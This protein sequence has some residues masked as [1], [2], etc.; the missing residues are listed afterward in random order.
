MTEATSQRRRVGLVL[1]GGGARGAY[2]A[3][4]LAH[5]FEEIY[6]QLPPGFEFDVLSGTSVGAIHAAYVAASAHMEPTPRTRRLA[7]TW[8]NMRV[9][10]VLQLSAGDLFGIPLRALGMTRLGKRLRAGAEVIGGL[11]DIAPLE[12][13][14]A[15]RIPWDHLRAN[16]ERGTPGALCVS[17]T[18]V[19]TGR[20]NVFM[21]GPLAD[22]HPWEFDPNTS[23]EPTELSPLHVR[24]SAAI[25][26]F[27]PA[28]RIGERYY[29]DGGLRVNTP[30]SPALRLGCERVLVVGLKHLA[31]L[32]EEPPAYPEEV[33]AQPVFMLGKVLNALMLDRLEYDLQRVGLVNALIEHGRQIY[34]GD[35]LEKLNVAV[36]AQRGADY[37]DVNALTLRPSQ[38]IGVIAAESYDRQ[39]RR[40]SMGI[41]PALLTRVAQ[42]GVPK[43][44]ADLLSYLLFDR[45]FTK[46][47]MELGREDAKAQSD[48]IVELLSG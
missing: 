29:L 44:E 25:P 28:V 48:A 2:E 10:D 47:L 16:L 37:R 6:P 41:L 15:Q 12:R 13:L 43:G 1:S 9:N 46:P 21:E 14:V 27:F 30:L 18:Q 22:P 19:R 40:R 36:R 23:A 8:R 38:D 5:L 42:V 20:V 26:F 33:I 7:D 34:G 24:A 35:F 32:S 31:G 11:V 39:S 45:C 4:V 3:G 17:C